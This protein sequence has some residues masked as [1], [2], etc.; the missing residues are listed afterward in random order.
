MAIVRRYV[1]KN[2]QSSD[3]Q[4]SGSSGATNSS[5][6]TKD[7][8]FTVEEYNSMLENGTWTGGYVQGFGYCMKSLDVYGSS[9]DFCSESDDCSNDGFFSYSD[10]DPYNPSN[11]STNN[12]DESY[13]DDCAGG[14]GGDNGSSNNS[15]TSSGSNSGATSQSPYSGNIILIIEKKEVDCRILTNDEANR[16]LVKESIENSMINLFNRLGIRMFEAVNSDYLTGVA[17]Y[18]PDHNA[19]LIDNKECLYLDAIHHE[20]LHSKQFELGATIDTCTSFIEFEVHVIMALKKFLFDENDVNRLFRG[21]ANVEN[22]FI[23]FLHECIVDNK[24]DYTRFAAGIT[25]YFDLF[26]QAWIDK[27]RYSVQPG[28]NETYEYK[29]KELI[30]LF[31]IKDSFINL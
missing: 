24:I 12:S 27:P 8:P 28:L 20:L 26:R 31:N 9:S 5:K 1:S 15:G 11:D 10:D 6:G 2:N 3:S 4:S 16:I 21:D 30:V 19:I 23:K 17:S 29:W 7:N 13:N 25:S 14:Y 18:L 22:M